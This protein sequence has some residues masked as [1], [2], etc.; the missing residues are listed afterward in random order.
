MTIYQKLLNTIKHHGCGFMVL[1]DPDRKSGDELV[2]LVDAYDKAGVDAYLFGSSILMVNEFERRLLRVK[3]ATEKPVII[4]PA[5]SSMVC[6]GADAILYLS[7]ISGRNANL[8]IEEHV[9]SAPMIKALGLEPIPT[10]Y[11]LIESGVL[12]SVSYLSHTMPIPRDKP[13]IA[14]AH[15]LAGQY[16]G[17]KLIYLE[18]G[19]GAMYPVPPDTV[20]AVGNY[21]DIPVMVGGGITD[22]DYAGE[23]ARAGAS[24]IIIGNA[25]ERK[26]ALVDEFISAVH[27]K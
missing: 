6:A 13:E 2:A 20:T 19:S 9:K 14:C 16:L 23:L 10:G 1:L 24:M 4:F 8:L 17:M 27:R 25:L 15:A 21:I 26:P 22:P 12:T 5:S 18:A 7:L 11:M 3:K